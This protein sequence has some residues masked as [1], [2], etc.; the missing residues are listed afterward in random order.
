MPCRCSYSNIVNGINNFHHHFSQHACHKY[1]VCLPTQCLVSQKH[2][3]YIAAPPFAL[4]MPKP[5][6]PT[7][8]CWFTVVSHS[9]KPVVMEKHGFQ[10][11]KM[12]HGERRAVMRHL[13]MHNDSI[14]GAII[15]RSSQAAVHDADRYGRCGCCGYR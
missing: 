6:I 5:G 13:R 1:V 4:C 12:P 15:M 14:D 7:L 11:E 9:A 10:L 8:G 2:F 3:S